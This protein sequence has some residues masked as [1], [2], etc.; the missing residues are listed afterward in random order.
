[1]LASGN[2]SSIFGI[3]T[4]VDVENQLYKVT[5]SSALHSCTKYKRS[6]LSG[7]TNT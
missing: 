4:K 6:H 7:P 2:L 1:M 5:L 3:H